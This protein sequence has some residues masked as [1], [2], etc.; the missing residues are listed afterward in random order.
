MDMSLLILREYIDIRGWFEV[1]LLF[2]QS[3]LTSITCQIPRLPL[4]PLTTC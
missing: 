4:I 3:F 2:L 1:T